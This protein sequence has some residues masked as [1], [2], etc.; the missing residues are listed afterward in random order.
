MCRNHTLS[1]LV[2]LAIY[3]LPTNLFAQDENKVYQYE[4][5]RIP[6]KNRVKKQV[7]FSLILI[8]NSLQS[9]RT[10]R[11]TNS[12]TQNNVTLPARL[13]RER[14]ILSAVERRRD[15]H[16]ERSRRAKLPTQHS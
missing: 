2:L 3:M 7:F 1:L 13:W 14:V 9:R 6:T 11:P 15:C 8:Q 12:K 5:K 10:L 16:P 4:K